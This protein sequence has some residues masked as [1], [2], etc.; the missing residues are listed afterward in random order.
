MA[1]TKDSFYVGYLPLPAA[2]K[3]FVKI[4]IAAGFFGA[5]ALAFAIAST[6]QDPGGGVWDTSKTFAI[7][8]HLS[9]NPYPIV[10]VDDPESSVGVTAV[11]LVSNFK[12]GAQDRVV[13]LDGKRVRA[14]GFF[15]TNGG[16]AM[17]ELSDSQDAV[18]VLREESTPPAN[19]LLGDFTL[20]GEIMDSKCFLGV[21]KP[22]SG[23][24][25]RACAV[26]CLSGGITPVFVTRDK[27]GKATI[28]VLTDSDYG[29]VNEQVLAYVAEPVQL[30]GRLERHGDLLVYA[31]DPANIVRK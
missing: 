24:T 14:K 12:F 13:G 11:L 19:E 15:I 3:P 17:F 20:A 23:K 31:I 9:V 18:T 26:R 27:D 2:L 10:Y 5:I 29:P 8:G 6:Q 25:H 4:F 30:N 1:E 21:M 7:E 16:R 28:Y 22:G